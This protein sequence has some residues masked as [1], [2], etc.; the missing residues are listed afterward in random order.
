MKIKSGFRKLSV[1]LSRILELSQFR[2]FLFKTLFPTSLNMSEDESN[3]KEG[4]VS[5]EELLKLWHDPTF[6]G[7][8]RGV[9][10]FQKLLKTDLN[11]NIS[12]DR[13][14]KILKTDQLFLI[15]QRPKRNFDRRKYD[16]HFYGQLVQIDIA[17]MFPDSDTKEHYFLLL[18]DVYSFKIFA[19]PLKNKTSDEVLTALKKIFFQFNQQ[20]YEI[21]ADRGKEFLGKELS[22]YLKKKHCLLRFKRGKN[23]A[24]FAEYGILLVKKKLYLLLRSALS[25]RWV[26]FLPLVTKSLNETPL[27]RLGWLKPNDVT[28]EA[29]S[30]FVDKAKDS[31]NIATFQN[32]TYQEQQKNQQFYSGD[33]NIGDY[34]YLDFDQKLFDKSFDVSVRTL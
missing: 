25:H 29:S 12:Q 28:S 6:T 2:C 3:F 33:L 13:L 17:Y 32:P 1:L 16:V 11:L 4:V 19:E 7:S 8:F 18:I 34:V 27:K 15:H 22:T 31:Y 14:Y 24:S 23:K 30:V 20:I 9:S 21:Q 5:D 10:T 26:H